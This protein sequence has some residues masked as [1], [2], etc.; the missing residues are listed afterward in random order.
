VD[1][2]E[3]RGP[4]DIDYGKDMVLRALLEGQFSKGTSSSQLISGHTIGDHSYDHM[5][6]TTYVDGEYVLGGPRYVDA[7]EDASYF[8]EISFAPIR[9]VMESNGFSQADINDRED[10]FFTWARM[11]FTNN[12]RVEGVARQDCVTCSQAQTTE[13]AVVSMEVSDIVHENAGTNM[14]GWDTDFDTDF[15][16]RR[17]TI[18]AIQLFM[19]LLALPNAKQKNKVV[20]LDHCQL[21]DMTPEESQYGEENL[22]TFKEFIR[23]AQNAGF[24]FRNVAT[25]LTD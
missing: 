1:S 18:N 22:E 20:L 10:F 13:S 5:E 6:H 19:R 3:I 12:W 17:Y 23:L 2:E 11:P 15:A 9:D 8:G 21:H 25:Y 14:M 16:A 24:E 4:E 7:E